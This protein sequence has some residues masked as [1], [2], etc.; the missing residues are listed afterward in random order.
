MK[1]ST[2]IQS[3]PIMLNAVATAIE[4]F[5][6]TPQQFELFNNYPNPFSST[7]QIAYTI[8]VG[9]KVRLD[10]YDVLGRRILTIYEGYK[11]AGTYDVTFDGC[12]LASGAYICRMHTDFGDRT[13]KLLLEK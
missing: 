5:V 2:Q 13:V 6:N 7:T 4:Q 3:Y 10:L 9:S 1:D 11:D 8:P 12:Y